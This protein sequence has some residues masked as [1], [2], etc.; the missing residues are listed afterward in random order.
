MQ[1]YFIPYAGYFRLFAAADLFVA[2]DCVQFPRR[3]WVHRN[4]LA[5]NNGNLQWITLPLTKGDRDSTRICDLRFPSNATLDYSR[6]RNRFGAIAKL[7]TRYPELTKAIFTLLNDP[8][9]YLIQTLSDI[10]ALL[11]I[12]KPIVRSSSLSIPDEFRAQA[13][14]IEIARRL[15]ASDYINA[16]GGRE[17]YD[18]ASFRQHGLA[19]H[20]LPAYDGNYASIVDRLAIDSLADLQA[21]MLA[22]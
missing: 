1:P 17:L 15:G 20:F 12:E 21:E 10:S 13:R 4:R 3:G 11:H 14:I 19:L 7:N 22:V 8:M 5:D 2:L 6:S 18:E 16:P 9:E